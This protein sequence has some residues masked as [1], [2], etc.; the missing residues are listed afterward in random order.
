MSHNSHS[1]S[2]LVRFVMGLSFLALTA[3]LGGFVFQNA[4][5]TRQSPGELT[6]AKAP[7]TTTPLRPKMSLPPVS[8]SS[9]IRFRDVTIGSGVDFTYYGSP[10]NRHFMTEQNGGGVALFDFDA[11]GRLDLF[12][13]NGSDFVDPAADAGASNRLYRNAGDWKFDDSTSSAGMSS[14]GF[15]MG[16]AVGDF[17]NDGFDDLV[18]TGYG[19]NRLYQNN[20]DGTLSPAPLPIDTNDRIWS[21]S[22]AFADFD[23]DGDLDLYIVNYVEWDPDDPPCFTQHNPPVPISC[24][25]IGRPG[26]SDRLYENTGDGTFRDVSETAGMNSVAGKGLGLSV[27]DFDGDGRLDLY[28]ANDTTENQLWHNRGGLRFEDV[29]LEHGVAVGSDGVARSG[30]GVGC[31][32]GNGDGRFDLIVTNFEGEPNDYYENQ[33]GL[34]FAPRNTEL[35]LDPVS[36]PVLGFGVVF[37]DFD[38]DSFPDLFIANG[39]VWD[40]TSLGLGYS[41]AMPQHLLRNDHGQKFDDVSRTAGDYFHTPAVA[42]AVATGDLDGDGDPDLVVT[43]LMRQAVLLQNASEIASH[44]VRLRFTGLQA[45]RSPLGCQV[46]CRLGQRHL[47]LRIPAGDSFQASSA[48]E[49]IVPIAPGETFDEVRIQW[50]SGHTETWDNLP[51]TGLVLLREGTGRRGAEVAYSHR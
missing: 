15:G 34:A 24:G 50:R 2:S 32:D 37:A 7:A 19:A 26:Q 9:S 40:L 3:L 27:A 8:N 17:N 35:R 4:Q 13:V 39:H 11:D 1:P 18:V 14:Y 29:A 21:T 45:A 36:R 46:T 16:C 30:M 38:L 48:P 31:A 44:G 22:A 51:A 20:G 47:A 28:V 42:R 23:D 41:F 49:V 6:E 33:G 43:H 12:L 10:T 5:S 25:P